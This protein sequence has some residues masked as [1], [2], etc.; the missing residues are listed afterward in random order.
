MEIFVYFKSIT[1]AML[2]IF[3]LGL[4]GFILVRKKLLSGEGV[5]GLTTF[6]IEVTF[7][8]LIF[9][10]IIAKFD[11]NLYPNWWLFSLAS[12]II[13]ALG[14]L[15][16]YLFSSSLKDAQLRREFM[17]LVGFQNAGYLP[18][19][20]FGWIV[21]KEELS[22]AL[23]YLFLFLLGFNLVIW[24]WGVY[25]LSS[26]KLKK[27]SCVSIFSPPVV[28]TLLGFA[29]VFFR[30]NSFIPKFILTPLEML[31]SCS[32]PLAIVV[33]GASLADLYV[34]KPFDKKLVLKLILAK[35]IVLPLLG[36]LFLNYFR[37]PYLI[38]LLIILELAVPSA[39][40]LAVIVRRYSK[41]EKIISQGIFLSH[42]V[43]L[44]T[45]PVFLALFNLIVFRL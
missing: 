43:S 18:L 27:F 19:T 3:L 13:T 35:L 14:L 2:Q 28:A 21:P 1:Q 30:I 22:S 4:V 24:S 20:L 12:L 25:F 41:E 38:G 26:H 44:I 17:S 37:L 32:F 36:L 6:L 40:S 34:A 33:V 9:W 7:P 45:L 29:F 8:A 31:G 42:I 39:T 5:S 11:F 23:I 15:V 10:Q 16:G